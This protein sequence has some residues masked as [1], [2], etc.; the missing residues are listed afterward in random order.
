MII[1]EHRS[2]CRECGGAIE[3]GETIRRDEYGFGWEHVDCEIP[4]RT[5]PAQVCP[6]CF[7]VRPCPCDDEPPC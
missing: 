7:L 6:T 4:E 2:V 1:A 3:P 5:R